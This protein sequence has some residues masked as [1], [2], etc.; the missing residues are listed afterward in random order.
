MKAPVIWFVVSA[1]AR[2][3]AWA[4]VNRS[5]I[6]F[7]G[8][9]L[10]CAVLVLSASYAAHAA[11]KAQYNFNQGTTGLGFHL[12]GGIPVPDL[13]GNDYTMFGFNDTFSP[14]YSAA[15]DTPSGIGLSSRH[16]GSQDGF[17][18]DPAF[19]TW[20]P[21]A[22]TIEVWTKLDDVTGWRT[23]ITRDG[24]SEGSN[25]NPSDFYLQKNAI[26][27]RFTVNFYTVGGNRY[28][29][30]S[31]FLPNANQWYGLAV[32]SDGSTLTMYANKLDG[33]GHQVVGTLAL[34]AA[35]NSLAQT[36]ANWV[37]GR[38]W[39]NGGFFDHILGNLDN[40]RFS[41]GVLDPSEFLQ[42]PE[43]ASMALVGLGGLC[44]CFVARRRG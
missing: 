40:V 16:N 31:D 2:C 8:L 30:D 17:T 38:G 6:R 3:S 36:G 34:A 15:G 28:I 10:L 19:N 22:W 39:F 23:L 33:M 13:S 24:G 32:T 41:D 43:P 42:V 27:N 29:L 7:A 14:H 35:D 18:L 44:L 9:K 26:N 25:P 20:S 5:R 21:S 12:P 11:T 4:C 37:F 1:A